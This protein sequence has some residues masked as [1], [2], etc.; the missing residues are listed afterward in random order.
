VFHPPT[1]TIAFD[2]ASDPVD[3]DTSRVPAWEILAADSAVDNVRRVGLFEGLDPFGRLQPLLGGERQKNIV[4]TFTL[5]EPITETPTNG[6]VE[7]WVILNF[8]GDAH[9][10]HLHRTRFRTVARYPIVYDSNATEDGYCGGVPDHNELDGV[11]LEEKES[12]QYGGPGGV[13]LKV[14]F[15][16]NASGYDANK[17]ITLGSEYNTEIG[18]RRD[19]VTALPGQATIIR[20]KF[21]TVGTFM[22][23]CHILSHEDSEMMRAYKIVHG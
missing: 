16:V 12:M 15:P 3:D 2:V 7:E 10:I 11:C 17:P 21:D 1:C 9:P 20:I 5:T 18:G 13:G 23:H 22:W 4:E 6:T 14:Y 8:S 19:T